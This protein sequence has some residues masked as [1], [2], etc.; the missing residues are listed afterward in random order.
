MMNGLPMFRFILALTIALATGPSW[1]DSAALKTLR[2]AADS[3]G[4]EGVGRLNFGTGSFCTAAL[5]TTDVVLTAA[6]CLF[7]R[8]SGQRIPLDR[9]EFQ[10]GL[11]FGH[12][13]AKRGVLRT[14]VHPGYSFTNPDRLMGVGNDLALLQLDQPVPEERIRPFRRRVTVDTGQRVHVISY[15]KDRAEAPAREDDCG[16]LTRDAD[17]LVLS[18]SVDFGSSGAPVFAELDGEVRLISVISAKAEWEGRPVALAAA[19]ENDI[20]MLLHAFDREA[21]AADAAA[22]Q[23]DLAFGH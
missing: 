22:R 21:G 4:W 3:R 9:L 13:D 19:M 16:V 7:E 23:V 18:C 2:T 1:A 17:I 5:V 15:A 20:D 12:A 11:R 14:V 6:H 8:Q 10:A